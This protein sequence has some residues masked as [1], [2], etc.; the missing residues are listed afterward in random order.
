MA[1][2]IPFGI[3]IVFVRAV[4]E[5]APLRWPAGLGYLLAPDSQAERAARIKG[6]RSQGENARNYL[7]PC[8]LQMT[9]S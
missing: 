9:F 2:G 1:Y 4:S 7:S 6:A 3:S 5:T 8:I